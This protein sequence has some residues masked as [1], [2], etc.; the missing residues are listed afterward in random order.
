MFLTCQNT[1]P[2]PT[3]LVCVTTSSRH[4]TRMSGVSEMELINEVINK[5]YEG[6]FSF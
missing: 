3:N 5:E 2:V 4:P 1:K 6:N